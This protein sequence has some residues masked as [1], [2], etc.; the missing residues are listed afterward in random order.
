MEIRFKQRHRGERM[1]PF[2]RVLLVRH[3]QSSGREPEAP[4]T[5][6]GHQ[7]AVT[8]A[9]YLSQ[10]D[11]RYIVTSP[12]RRALQTI[13]PFARQMQLPI[14]V[15]ERF[16]ARRLSAH[17]L[18]DWLSH[19]SES[20]IDFD[21]RAPGGESSRE[22]QHRGRMALEAILAQTREL[23]V[24]VT[25]GNLLTLILHSI[26]ASFG[27]AAW[28]RLTNPDIYLVKVDS[29]KRYSFQRM[30]GINS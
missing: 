30:W 20:F 26:D 9:A 10:F 6:L 21:H 14:H 22:A 8:L 13:E 11:I 25:H 17:P 12:F 18:E 28:E 7:Q 5:P 1:L 15:D 29:Q 24:V 2:R 23:P 16:A 27:F 19:I 3:C 4:L